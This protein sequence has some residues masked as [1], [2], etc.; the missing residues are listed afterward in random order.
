MWLSRM[1]C[2]NNLLHFLCCG[3]HDVYF[4]WLCIEII[5][6]IFCPLSS[7]LPH[8]FL[9]GSSCNTLSLSHMK[10]LCQK[11]IA[12]AAARIC[13]GCC[14]RK[15]RVDI[16]IAL[17]HSHDDVAARLASKKVATAFKLTLNTRNNMLSIM[18]N[19]FSYEI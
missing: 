18:T 10:Q 8:Y 1:K 14:E 9:E 6:D 5:L 13:W 16:I 4:M 12:V 15:L 19:I 2:K 7:R 17:T 11:W 3:S